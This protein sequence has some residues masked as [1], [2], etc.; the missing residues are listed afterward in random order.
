MCRWGKESLTDSTPTLKTHS[1][2]QFYNSDQMRSLRQQLL[3]GDSP[4]TCSTCYYEQSFGKLNGRLRQLNKSAIDTKNFALTARSSPHFL[5]FKYSNENQGLANMQPVDLQIDLGNTCNSSCIMCHPAASSR[6]ETDYKKLHI[7]NPTLFQSPYQYQPWTKDP[8][9]VDQ[10]IKQIS[11][12]TNLKYIHF[13]G[14]ETLF[15]QSFYN[16]CDRLIDLDIA[17]NIII[18]TTTNGTIYNEKIKLYI[19]KF[20]GF[21]LGISIE[22]VTELNDYIRYP[23]NIT[24]VLENTNRFLMMRDNNPGLYIS[25]RI[26]PNVFSIFEIDKL[27]VY[28]IENNVIAESCNILIDPAQ[29]KIELLPDDLRNTVK[30]KIKNIIDYYELESS[31]IV[32]VRRDDLIPSV[33]ANTVLDYYKFICEYSAPDNVNELRQE[34]VKFIEAFEVV[35]KNSILNYL[36]EYE[37]FLRSYGF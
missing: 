32:N 15:E 29:L 14:G 28:M 24:N 21:H 9:L 5:N 1:I 2:M 26:T 36:P 20:K 4:D 25:L 35:H 3:S 11:E 13:L 18:G 34:L 22:S 12:L 8:G 31:D 6:L 27:F 33:I 16:I 17:K 30:I 10:V 7:I 37:N 19:E 23:S